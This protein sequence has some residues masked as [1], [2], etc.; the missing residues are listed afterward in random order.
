MQ[1]IILI[2]VR[3]K[4]YSVINNI[5]IILTE[6]TDLSNTKSVGCYYI[7]QA[8]LNAGFNIKYIPFFD[9]K[10]TNADIY[11]FSIHHV[12]DIFNFKYI[13]KTIKEKITIAGGHCM[14][15]P[16]PFLHWFD[17]IC[18]GE[19]ETWIIKILKLFNSKINKK[20]FIKE[21]SQ[22]SGSL[23]LYN[24]DLPVYKQYEKS[25]EN[26]SYYLNCSNSS[27]HKDTWYIEIGRGCKSK[28][29]YCEL[30]WTS[31]YREK[32][33]EKVKEQID[34]IDKKLSNRVNIFSPDDFSHKSYDE[35]LK[36]ILDLKL[37][38]NFGSMRYDNFALIEKQHKKNFLFRIGLDGLSDRIRD[39]VNKKITN[40]AIINILDELA[41]RGFVMFKLFMIFSYTFENY[42]DFQRFLAFSI[43][44]NQRMADLKRPIFLR[45]K[46]TPLIPNPLTPVEYFTPNYNIEMRKNID[47]FFLDQ[48]YAKRTN[49]VYIDDGI[50]EPFNYYAQAFLARADYEDLM[51][52]LL[53]NRKL[54]NFKAEE[55]AKTQKPKRH[56]I[57]AIPEN[58]R[59]E[60]FQ[61]MQKKIKEYYNDI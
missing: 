24:L 52:K 28:C 15:N 55:L 29:N 34:S 60:A 59:I 2:P 1:Q 44:L 54:F 38:T 32:N 19:G 31:K 50:L 56:I 57:T 43:N 16:Y 21:A 46:F 51:P 8:I 27:G 4:N 40:E 14:N 20:E 49:I 41:H 6:P 12:R 45:I 53:K 42:E 18:V 9:L 3:Q 39:I 58:K 37:I 26:T 25:I 17:V 61:K 7:E 36:Y 5:K 48:K 33:K 11:L 22:I 10:K 47:K 35:I 13:P 30:G 23:T